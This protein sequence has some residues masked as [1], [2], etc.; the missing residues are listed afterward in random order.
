MARFARGLAVLALGAGV[1]VAGFALAHGPSLPLSGITAAPSAGGGSWFFSPDPS[2]QSPVRR[3]RSESD[4]E[5]RRAHHKRIAAG[6]SH[7]AYT[8]NAVCVRL[9]DGSFFP[10]TSASSGDAG[11]ASQCP[12]APT[13]LYAMTSDHIEDSYAM[14]SGTPYSK[15]PVASR[16]QQSHESTCSCQRDGVASHTK[17]LMHDNS[18]RKGDVVMTAEGF[19]VFE[20]SGWG[21]ARPQDFIAVS[22]AG[23]PRDQ[24]AQ[25][26]AMEHANAGH[27]APAAPPTVVAERTKGN[28]TVDDGPR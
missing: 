5:G 24:S 16:F 26:S 4:D 15:L 14:S 25:L 11:C 10:A 7:G 2:E 22:K 19:R 18:L 23:L 27:I 8:G 3:V 17:E 21:P 9:C 6:A 1:I 28:V 12:G 20:G 13:E